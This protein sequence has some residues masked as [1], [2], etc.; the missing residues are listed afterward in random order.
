MHMEADAV[1]ANIC[2]HVLYNHE[3]KLRVS[4]FGFEQKARPPTYNAT[5]R[6][7]HVG[8]GIHLASATKGAEWIPI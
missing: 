7:R 2:R 6:R 3:P 8:H 5:H 1:N 4:T